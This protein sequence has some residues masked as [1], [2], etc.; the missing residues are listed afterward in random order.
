MGRR[1][2]EGLTY[3]Q[4]MI[5]N[6]DTPPITKAKA[7]YLMSMVEQEKSSE[8]VKAYLRAANE[9][10]QKAKAIYVSDEYDEF[11]RMLEGEL[12]KREAVVCKQ[13]QKVLDAVIE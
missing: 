13:E 4:E 5:S 8:T 1:T 11:L 12:E 3:V 6:K 9:E 7:H 10:L 2:G